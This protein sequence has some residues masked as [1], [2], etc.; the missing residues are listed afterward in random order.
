[1]KERRQHEHFLVNNAYLC[2]LELLKKQVMI[3]RIYI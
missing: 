3:F 2:H 1:M